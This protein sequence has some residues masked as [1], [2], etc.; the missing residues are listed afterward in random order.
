MNLSNYLKQN[1][2]EL[3]RTAFEGLLRSNLKH[4][5]SSTANENW[6]RIEKL[7]DLTLK[8]VENKSLVEMIEYSEK[9]AAERFNMGFDLHEVHT[10][11]NV[12]EETLWKE[13][14]NNIEMKEIGKALGLVSTILGA[15]KE[16]LALTYLSLAGKAKPKTLD[17]SELFKG[18]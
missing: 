16:T 8:S 1:Q 18:N 9:I 13:I 6:Q 7:F 11:Y 12:L 10:A 5:S 17:L 14:L 15:G 4:Y 3:I 2:Q